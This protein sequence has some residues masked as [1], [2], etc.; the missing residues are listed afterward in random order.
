MTAGRHSRLN[1]ERDTHCPGYIIYAPT[2][3]RFD[4]VR[5]LAQ[6]LGT[7]R[8]ARCSGHGLR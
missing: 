7:A 8:Y 1:G 3:G 4:T 2:F 5:K 6:E